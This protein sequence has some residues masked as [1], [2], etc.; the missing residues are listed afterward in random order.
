MMIVMMMIIMMMMMMMIVMMPGVH[1]LLSSGRQEG[2][3][4]DRRLPIPPHVCSNLH[5]YS[6]RLY[7]CGGSAAHP[8]DCLGPGQGGVPQ[9]FPRPHG[10]AHPLDA[11]GGRLLCLLLPLRRQP[12]PSTA[13]VTP[14]QQGGSGRVTSCCRST[15]WR[16]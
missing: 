2:C 14:S 11:D 3:P 1:P 15:S 7:R 10:E 4:H 6:V 9:H 5:N 12:G 13:T 8:G 16:G